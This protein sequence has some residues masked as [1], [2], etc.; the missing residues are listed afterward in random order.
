MKNK[1]KNVKTLII[2]TI[3]LLLNLSLIINNASFLNFLIINTL[4]I[5]L[6]FYYL[7]NGNDISDKEYFLTKIVLI[8]SFCVQIVKGLIYLL[9]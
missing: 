2:P 9:F 3:F 5:M 1:L 8:I 7:E 6:F 4:V